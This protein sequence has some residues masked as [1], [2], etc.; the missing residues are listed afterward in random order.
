MVQ[1]NAIETCRIYY[2]CNNYPNNYEDVPC[3]RW[4]EDNWS[5]TIEFACTSSQRDNIFKYIT[6]GA[7]TEQYNILGTPYYKDLTYNS[8][9]TLI[10]EP[11]SG[12]GLSSV[13]WSRTVAVKNAS[14]TFL[15]Y[16]YFLCKLETKRLDV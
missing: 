10:F 1:S 8:G 4:D 6:P 9:N 3:T 15:N 14:D 13:R 5:V 16:E 7:V 2:S 12:Y 11:I